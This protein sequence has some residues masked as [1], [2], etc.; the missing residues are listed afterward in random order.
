MPDIEA[1]R[2]RKEKLGEK[3]AGLVNEFQEYSGL[4]VTWLSLEHEKVPHV[5]SPRNEVTQ[6]VRE[7]QE[8]PYVENVHVE[9]KF[10]EIYT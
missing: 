5:T 3:I 7:L 1:V 6:R 10:D 4:E 2:E 9:V 8:K